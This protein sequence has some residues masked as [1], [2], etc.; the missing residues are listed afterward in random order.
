MNNKKLQ[1]Y[2]IYGEFYNQDYFQ[3]YKSIIEMFLQFKIV[4]DVY[5]KPS[6]PNTIIEV[7]INCF[8]DPSIIN[9]ELNNSTIQNINRYEKDYIIHL[10]KI[11][12]QSVLNNLLKVERRVLEYDKDLNLL[13]DIEGGKFDVK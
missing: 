8:N 6:Y 7:I 1:L 11:H 9:I 3:K 13:S 10:L 5:V 2:N 4:S 12:T